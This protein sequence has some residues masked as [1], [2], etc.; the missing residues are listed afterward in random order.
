MAG[1][2]TDRILQVHA[3]P[4]QMKESP[5]GL[6]RPCR[7]IRILK[8]QEGTNELQYLVIKPEL[9]RDPKSR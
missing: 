6:D 8:I 1:G 2:A 9:I 5:I 4:D 7:D 3:G